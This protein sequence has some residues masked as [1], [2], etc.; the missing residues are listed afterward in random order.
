[1]MDLALSFWC[2]MGVKED[3]ESLKE[4]LS[5]SVTPQQQQQLQDAGYTT[6]DLLASAHFDD[7]IADPPKLPRAVARL[8]CEA[9]QNSRSPQHSN[10][11][12]ASPC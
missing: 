10:L 1:M 2:S 11:S 7:L 3:L 4:G 8:I 9:N 12:F 5:N 6:K